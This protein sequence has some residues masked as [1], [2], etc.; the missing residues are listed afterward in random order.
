MSEHRYMYPTVI[1]LARSGAP[2]VLQNAGL[3]QRS[4]ASTDPGRRPTGAGTAGSSNEIDA[5]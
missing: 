3:A 2:S 5:W 4:P 1:E